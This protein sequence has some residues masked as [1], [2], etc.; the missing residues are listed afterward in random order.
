MRIGITR[1]HAA[2][3]ALTIALFCSAGV[4]AQLVTSWGAPPFDDGNPVSDFV[5]TWM[6]DVTTGEITDIVPSVSG[7]GLAA[8]N[9]SGLLYATTGRSLATYGVDPNGALVQLVNGV[10]I[11]D[12]E[13]TGA[14]SGQVAA[15][16]FADGVLYASVGRKLVDEQRD[17]GIE[18]GTYTIDPATAVA[19]R[20]L[21][22]DEF[23]LFSGFDY[24]PDDE[25][26]YGLTGPSNAQTIVRF[27]LDTFTISTVADVPA[28]AY[29]EGITS[30]DGVGVGEGRVY[31]T[32]GLN[33]SYGDVPIAVFNIASGAFEPSLPS[34]N[35]T[36][37]NRF[38]PAGAAFFPALATLP[39]AAVPS[40]PNGMHGTTPFQL[41]RV[42]GT[43]AMIRFTWDTQSCPASAYNVIAGALDD[44]ATYAVAEAACD[45]GVDGTVDWETELTGNLF[46]LVVGT[47]GA[48]MEGSLGQASAGAERNAGAATGMCGTSIKAAAGTCPQ[49]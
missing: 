12:T 3:A 1:L 5:G 7:R 43:G 25:L 36:A 20:I 26:M 13:G 15:L 30:F 33:S 28:E 47:D 16:A 11:H 17:R 42:D 39:A 19:T 35:R 9:T 44:V 23:Q 21:T 48:D 40:V 22:A 46:F 38:Y 14:E 10:R 32:S 34:P 49:P 37:E 8:D 6:S 2:L 29:G 27:D 18:K 45:V 41:E 4:H 24:N 31:L